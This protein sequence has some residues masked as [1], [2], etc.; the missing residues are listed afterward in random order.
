MRTLGTRIDRI[1]RELEPA[2]GV[3]VWVPASDQI[4]DGR[5]RTIG[6]GEAIARAD[7]DRR[8]GRHILVRYVDGGSPCG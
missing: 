3:H 5:V 7:V 2:T 4:D 6:T 1:A 8:P